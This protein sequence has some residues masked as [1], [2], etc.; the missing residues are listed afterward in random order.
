VS[1]E[2]SYTYEPSSA[3]CPLPAKKKNISQNK[4]CSQS[5]KNSAKS[6]IRTLLI[7]EGGFVFLAFRRKKEKSKRREKQ[8]KPPR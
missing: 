5:L 7:P 8:N 2:T 1:I 6:V 3:Y 4:K